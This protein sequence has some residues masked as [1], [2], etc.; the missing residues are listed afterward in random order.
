MV[1]K[2]DSVYLNRGAVTNIWAR[3]WWVV[4]AGIILL[5][6]V[7]R[8]WN[9]NWDDGAYVLHHDEQVLNDAVRHLGP[10]LNP[11]FYHYG[12]FAIYLYRATA[13]IL[14]KVTGISWVSSTRLALV[15]RG[16]SA[17]ASTVL[18]LM[19]FLL[20]RRFWGVSAGLLAATF[21]AGAAMLIQ[22]A[23]YGTVDTLMT[24]EG[25]LLLWIACQ[26]AAD[27][28]RRWYVLAG[29]VLGLAI[30]TKLSAA[31]F[32]LLP[33]LAHLWRQSQPEQRPF[34]WMKWL[35]PLLLMGSVTIVVTLAVDPYLVLG[36]NEAIPAF[37]EQFNEM[38]GTQS[39]TWQ[40]IG[41]I[42]YVFELQNLVLWELGVP[43]GLA[44]LGGWLWA[45]VSCGRMVMA[46]FRPSGQQTTATAEG[47][48]IIQLSSP[49]SGSL[50]YIYLLLLTV[51]PTLYF[52]YIGTWDN[53]YVR[54]MMPLIP[55][56][57]L[58]AAGGLVALAGW[59]RRYHT[60]GRWLGWVVISVIIVG[61]I[62]WGMAVFSIFRVPDT[63][64]QAT[65]WVINNVPPKSHIVIE[66]SIYSA[67]LIPLTDRN[68][69]NPIYN[70]DMLD[71]RT[72]DTPDKMSQFADM[73]AHGDYLIVPDRIWSATLPRLPEFPLTANYYR[74]LFADNLGYTPAA[75]FADPPHLGPFSWPDDSAEETFQVFDHPTVRIFRNTGHLSAA[76][77]RAR[78]QAGA[79]GAVGSR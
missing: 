57:C 9:L 74:Q 14:S 19:M 63:R 54:Y 25:V 2:A 69:K 40:F 79:G 41:S 35:G 67:R 59:L 34:R 7:V 33:L 52:T 42:P 68:A 58:F 76:Q 65:G 55:Y 28:R 26:I 61:A 24:L 78:L 72:P 11:H 77:L 36:W 31:A 50:Q 20:G 27:G 1:S 56:C 49:N 64:L 51:W 38:G 75:T 4:L 71:V 44:A 43:L 45:L 15:G 62:G 73:L 30:A 8:F 48:Q 37:T 23:H 70:Y 22:Q 13:E 46:R 6:L 16:Y 17:L 47:E 18:V 21:A 60:A 10:D 12:S 32:A 53:R 66:S 5:A 39:W 3:A 29:V